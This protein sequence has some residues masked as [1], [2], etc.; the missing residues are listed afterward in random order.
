MM[1]LTLDEPNKW[2]GTYVSGG[3]MVAPVASSVMGEILPYL[4]IEPSYTAA[5]VGLSVLV[6]EHR[7]VARH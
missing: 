1:L 2:T 5:D 3:N 6:E 4:G 7:A